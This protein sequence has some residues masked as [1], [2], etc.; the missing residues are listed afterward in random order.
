MYFTGQGVP[1]DYV[2]AYMWRN[3]AVARASP[4]KQN[5]YVD[6]RDAVVKNMTSQQVAD[7]QQRAREWMEAFEHGNSDSG[8]RRQPSDE[9]TRLQSAACRI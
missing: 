4:E 6:A 9:N 7:S 5:E 1:L 8:E 2:E 3:L